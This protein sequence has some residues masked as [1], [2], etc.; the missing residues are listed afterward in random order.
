MVTSPC[1]RTVI[2]ITGNRLG[3]IMKMRITVLAF[4]TLI[5]SWMRNNSAHF[6]LSITESLFQRTLRKFLTT[7]GCRNIAFRRFVNLFHYLRRKSI[8]M[9]KS[10]TSFGT[11]KSSRSLLTRSFRWMNFWPQTWF[12]IQRPLK[13]KSPISDRFFRESR[14]CWT[15]R[16]SSMNSKSTGLWNLKSLSLKRKS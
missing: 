15:R 16:K 14:D 6:L 10:S 8:R 13:M 2:T 4:L 12:T 11:Q 7:F 9:G 1:H 3:L 5:P